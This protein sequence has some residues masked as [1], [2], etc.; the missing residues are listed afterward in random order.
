MLSQAISIMILCK[1]L[2]W[3]N[4]KY[5]ILNMKLISGVLLKGGPDATKKINSAES[6]VT[7]NHGHNINHMQIPHSN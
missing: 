3:K 2:G 4:F 5:G 1:Y 6:S 7:S